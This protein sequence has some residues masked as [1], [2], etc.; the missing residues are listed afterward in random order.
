MTPR[1]NVVEI[2]DSPEGLYEFL[3]ST[4][5]GDGLPCIAPT[6]A[7]VEAMLG[8]TPR[9]PEEV[10]GVLLP[11]KG[12]ASVEAVA[13]NAVMAG[14]RP[15]YFPVVL[16]AVESVLAGDTRQVQSHTTNSSAAMLIVNG[17]IRH[18]IGINHQEGCLGVAG[19][20]N[21]TIGRAVQLCWTNIGGV[22]AGPTSK[23]VF[24]QPGRYTMCI[25]EWDEV[26]PW[27]PLHLHRGFEATDDAVTAVWATGT[28][29]VTDIW[30]R[31]AES[32]LL[33][34]AGSINVVTGANMILGDAEITVV[35]NPAW[36]EMFADEG[37]SRRDIQEF[38]WKESQLPLEAFPPEHAN[39][40]KNGSRVLDGGMVPQTV[41]ADHFVLVV[42]GGRGG[43]HATV[44][45]G[46]GHG[47]AHRP[48]SVTCAVRTTA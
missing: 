3:D 2:D 15:E 6:M 37:L 17:P 28:T 25:G 27:G 36:A 4:N 23:T 10:L 47:R 26:N 14:C 31:Y 1:H 30:S 19:R 29:L 7:R 48:P 33:G 38:L 43:L 41:D 44:V 11:R 39:A 45:H 34:I 20:A 5:S 9:D 13:V 40:L 21:A 32:Y 46:M 8:A 42:A 22:Q 35:L 24:G 18:Q 12:V 16:A